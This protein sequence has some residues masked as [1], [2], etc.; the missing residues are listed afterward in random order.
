MQATFGFGSR[1][2]V[3]LA[4]SLTLG[5]LAANIQAA[6]AGSVAVRPS[7]E[8]NLVVCEDTAFA[9]CAAS[10]CTP[11]GE[12]ITNNDG[13]RFPA[14]VCTCPVVVGDNVADLKGGNME[15]SC[16]ADEGYVYS[17]YEINGSYPQEIDGTWQVADAKPQVCPSRYAYVQCWNWKCEL[18][19][20][21]NGIQLAE[22]TCPIQ[23]TPYQWVTQAGQGE[24]EFCTDL[25]VGGPLFFDPAQLRLAR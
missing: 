7:H 14:A 21:V 8:R 10:T 2:K 23:K 16:E 12:F 15:G 24:K 4:A 25:P 5:L 1:G 11:T 3:V 17:T 6:G 18:G 19:D 9:L 13:L 22:C 20:V